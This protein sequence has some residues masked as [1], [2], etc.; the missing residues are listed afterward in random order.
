MFITSKNKNFNTKRMFLCFVITAAIVA[1]GLNSCMTS[2]GGGYYKPIED[3]D[4]DVEVDITDPQSI[5]NALKIDKSTLVKGE[6]P[7]PTGEHNFLSGVGSIEVGTGGQLNLP[8]IW[9]ANRSDGIS[10]KSKVHFQVSGASDHYSIVPNVVDGNYAYI[11]ITVPG[12]ID[13]GEFW[14]EYLIEEKSKNYSNVVKTKIVISN[15]VVLCD[16]N[17][18]VTGREG[19]TYTHLKLGEKKGDVLISYNT[20]S[21]PDRIDIFQGKKKGELTS[22][23]T[24]TGEEPSTEEIGRPHYCY[25]GSDGFVGRSGELTFDYKPSKGKFITIIVNGCLG[26]KT[27]W[28]FYLVDSP[29]NDNNNED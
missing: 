8:F 27:A 25:D 1:A 7:E 26:S 23:L 6:L 22:W 21:V 24:G 16:E 28:D 4:D 11:S 13:D 2:G 17:V 15:K 29:C 5:Q 12:N 3:E 18:N 14:I 20:Y 10:S 9:T 19:I